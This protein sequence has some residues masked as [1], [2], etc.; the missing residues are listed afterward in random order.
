MIDIL[1]SL[2]GLGVTLSSTSHA[3]SPQ[4]LEG[5]KSCDNRVI[6]VLQKDSKLYVKMQNQV[7]TMKSVATNTGVKNVSRFETWDG[8]IVFIQTPEKAMILDNMSMV[9]ITNECRNI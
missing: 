6:Q 4:Q 9:P 2:V 1:L 5:T 7:Y 8:S 3:A